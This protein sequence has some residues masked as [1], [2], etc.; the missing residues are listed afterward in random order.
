[1]DSENVKF[2]Y[3]VAISFLGQD[4]TLANEIYNLIND[5]LKTFTYT[6]KQEMI[7]GTDG[8]ATF[9]NIFEYDSRIA[10]VL[11][12]NN[13]GT[14]P[15]TRIEMDAIRNRAF[16]NGYDFTLFVVLDEN[17]ILPKWLPKNRIWWDFKKYGL[18]GLASVIEERVRQSGD[19]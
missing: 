18:N 2:Q 10:V 14:T 3:E 13:W 11:Y 19:L 1:M 15:F 17:P 9:K 6:K 8:E 4:E 5:R 12:R 16:D 7:A